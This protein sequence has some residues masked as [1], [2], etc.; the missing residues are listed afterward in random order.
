[1]RSIEK[2]LKEIEKITGE[3]YIELRN[4][5]EYTAIENQWNLIYDKLIH[6]F[7]PPKDEKDYKVLAIWTEKSIDELKKINKESE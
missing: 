4:S 3:K 1:M 6:F 2:V 7:I 5:I